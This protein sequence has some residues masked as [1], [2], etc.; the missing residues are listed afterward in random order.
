MKN[1]KQYIYSIG[2]AVCTLSCNMSQPSQYGEKPYDLSKFDFNI[3]IPSFYKNEDLFRGK[4]DKVGLNTE[5]ESFDLE[6]KGGK[7][8]T[9]HYIQ[10]DIS[11][12]KGDAVLAKYGNVDFHEFELVVD[13]Q[14][15]NVYVAIAKKEEMPQA[16]I[17]KLVDAIESDNK[18]AEIK[19]REVAQSKDLR[20]VWR[21]KDKVVQLVVRT[22]NEMKFEQKEDSDE[23]TDSDSFQN[24]DDT[25]KKEEQETI[26]KETIIAKYK[27]ALKNIKEA[28]VYIFISAPK[29][30]ED[31]RKSNPSSRGN[32]TQY[33]EGW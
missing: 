5:E 28:T 16:T 17:L 10:Y 2:I 1:I 4:V 19:S 29:F 22:S 21:S 33:K 25:P 13:D 11:S 7:D 26:P 23:N 6:L 24:D 3:D 8:T 32:M 12:I 15:K 30:D 31:F 9:I 18:N 27:E 20:L 14:E